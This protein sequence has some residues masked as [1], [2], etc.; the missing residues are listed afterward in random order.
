MISDKLD[1]CC[2]A[3]V[4]AMIKILLCANERTQ[5]VPFVDNVSLY[6]EVH[7]EEHTSDVGKLETGVFFENTEQFDACYC[8]L[9][10]TFK[11]YN[12]NEQIQG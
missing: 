5:H 11:P 9:K 8:N 12:R 10:S 6:G 2:I 3:T 7:Y 1:R 4:P